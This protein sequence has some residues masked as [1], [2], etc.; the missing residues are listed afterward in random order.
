MRDGPTF[1]PVVRSDLVDDVGLRLR[2]AIF[3]GDL[4]PGQRLV[5]DDL[6]ARLGVSRA[7]IRDAL[8][9]LEQDGLVTPAGK[10]GK[11][12]TILSVEDVW[13]VYSL[14]ATLEA[15]AVR[16]AIERG[17]GWLGELAEIVQAMNV[18]VPGGDRREFSA[19]DVEFHR[20]IGRASGHTRLVRSWEAI[21][22]QIRL[23]SQRVIDTQYPD[24]ADVAE[25]HAK[26]LRILRHGDPDAAEQAIREHIDSVAER[27]LE[28]MRVAS[29]ADGEGASVA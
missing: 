26:L 16:L 12:V 14:R 24:L 15:M 9:Q 19:L 25:R 28:V 17:A 22:T 11:I 2:A 4:A 20:T 7:P 3:G 18:A 10:R 6:A 27:V 5:E 1:E 21:A 8:K 13:E 23:L 29:A